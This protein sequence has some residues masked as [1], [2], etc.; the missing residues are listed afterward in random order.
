MPITNHRRGS[1][2][3]RPVV[4]TLLLLAA[5]ACD[6]ASASR[7]ARPERLDGEWAVELRLE[8]P[9]TLTRDAG[10][11]PPVRGTVVLLENARAR[12]VEGLSGIPTHVGVYAADL[13]PLGLRGGGEVP[14]LAARLSGDDSVQVAFDPEQGPPFA[15]RGV[16]A[17]DSVTGHWWAGG[18]RT[19]GRSSGRFVMRR[20]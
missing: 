3:T 7:P 12:R 11:A 10:G 14:T 17:G 6:H 5:S 20:P 8:H 16:L 15:G 2:A 9:V 1:R 13:R 19:A 18:G 4:S